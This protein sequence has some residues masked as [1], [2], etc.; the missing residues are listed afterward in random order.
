MVDEIHRQLDSCK[1]LYLRELSEPEE[2]ALRIVLEEAKPGSPEDIEIVGTIIKG[3][4]P[5]ESDQSCQ[6]FE[7]M[8]PNYV[9]YSVRNESYTSWDESEEWEGNSFRIYSKSHFL[10]YVAKGTFA[11]NE[12]PGPLQ[13][14]SF[15]CL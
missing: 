14:Y 11:S 10:N 2:N 15:L 3:T 1:W 8:W 7:A 12:Y 9:A 13:H 5:I 4:R 6:L